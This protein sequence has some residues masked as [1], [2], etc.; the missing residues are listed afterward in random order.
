MSIHILSTQ[1]VDSDSYGWTMKN[2]IFFTYFIKN[3]ILH[4][5]LFA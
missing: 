4:R 1:D 5:R 3:T 2:C